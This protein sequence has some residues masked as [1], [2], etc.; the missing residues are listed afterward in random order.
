[1]SEAKKNTSAKTIILPAEKAGKN[2]GKNVPA[3][4]LD[5]TPKAD[6]PFSIHALMVIEINGNRSYKMLPL[7]SELVLKDFKSMPPEVS[8]AILKLTKDRLA[9]I[10]EMLAALYDAEPSVQ[11]SK[12]DHINRKIVLHL[13]EQLQVLK[14]FNVIL[15]WYYQV[16]DEMLLTTSVTKPASFSNY[17][18]VVMFA[19]L[20][21]YSGVL[22]LVPMVKLNNE[23]IPY[24]EF[25]RYHFLLRSRNEFFILDLNDAATLDAFPDGY[26]DATD[27]KRFVEEVV[28]PLA[29]T[30]PVD[31]DVLMTN[32]EVTEPLQARVYLS[33]LNSNFLMITAKFL[34][35]N[36]E[37]DDDGKDHTEL[38]EEGVRYKINRNVDGEK[39]IKSLLGNMHTKF[40]SQRNGYYYL[41][42]T[43]AEKSQWFIKFYRKLVD[44]NIPVYGMEHLQHFR[45]NQ[46]IPV[47]KVHFNGKG[48]DWFDL[49]VEVS[50]GDQQVPLAELQ[51]AILNKQSVIL[52]KDGTIGAIPEEWLQQYAS[53]FK[54]GHLQKDKIRLS[55]LHYTLVDELQEGDTI[56]AKAITADYKEKWRKLQQQKEHLFTVPAK[57]K[58]TLRD[59]QRAGFEWLCLLD[60]MQW[61]GCLAD[62]MGLG[63]TLQTITF[64]QYVTDK[65]KAE[66]HLVICPT[67]LLYNWEN[68]LKKFAPELTYFIYYKADKTLDK[69]I[70]EQCNIILT[71]YGRVRNDIELLETFKFGYIICDESHVI[72][73]PAAQLSKAVN[74]LQARNKIVLSGTPIQ[75][76]TFDLYTQMNFINPGLLGNREFFRSEFSQPIDKHGDKEKATQLKKLIYPFLL[77]R[78]KEQVAKDLPTKTEITLWCE[79]GE[80]QRKAY[81]A[82]K[83]YYRE[84]L[85]KRIEKDGMGSSAV[86]ILE[87]LTKLRQACNAPQLISGYNEI[88][89]SVKLNELV[90]ELEENT[91]DHKV[92]V[93]S[94]FTGM[95]QL[96]A[97][98]LQEHHIAYYYLDGGTKAEQRQQLVQ[99]FQTTNE[100]K[101]FLISLKAG[102]VGLTL[103]AADYVYL[104]DPWWNPAAE[105]QAIDRAHRIG[106]TQKVF[107]YKM[108]CRDTVEEKILALQQRKKSLAE[109]LISEDTG[110]VKALTTEDVDYLFS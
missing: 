9:A 100:A 75:N 32:E 74:R 16:V 72:K 108:I 94:Q 109:D 82:I 103:T 8:R 62:D 44:K 2:K 38:T 78:T 52:L 87:G 107:A 77:R 90:S 21:I 36:F 83:N 10:K 50:F 58:A 93:F 99:D 5:L 28:N 51:K 22:R 57:V 67:S 17:R 27:E 3:L 73:N 95:L 11:E 23:I 110:F 86:Y 56:A 89:E 54:M 105:Q 30:Y 25:K 4:L 65:Y 61:G 60:E 13:Y 45:Y 66:T 91:G 19:L 15:K 42:F 29:E 31:M 55:K 14:P 64:L 12:D 46:H 43:E 34:Y 88:T 49:R 71:T 18:P 92:L 104:V 37:V 76:N 59:Y 6:Y 101:V 47:I 20:R 97:N 79:M 39:E 68:E 102:G 40:P 7:S 106:Q 1:M 35:G 96:I 70:L 53:I 69:K 41:S 26:I 84:S 63:K 33:E 98:K 80:E 24:A 85:L 81:D 48:I